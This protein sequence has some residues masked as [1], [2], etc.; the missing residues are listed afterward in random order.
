M[1][2]SFIIRAKENLKAAELLYENCLYN[3]SANRAYYAAFHAAIAGIYSIGI[4]PDIDHKT[5]QSLFSDYFFN[6]RKIYP[7]KFKKYLKDLQIN[8]NDADYKNGIS[9]RIAKQQLSYSKELVELI[10]GDI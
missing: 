7:S 10:L 3:A 5:V 2:E 9:K 1:K 4:T 8:R 6:R